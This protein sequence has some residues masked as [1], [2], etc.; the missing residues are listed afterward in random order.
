MMS[1]RDHA[2]DD[3]YIIVFHNMKMSSSRFVVGMYQNLLFSPFA[4]F[5]IRFTASPFNSPGKSRVPR[6][7]QS[8]GSEHSATNGRGFTNAAT[9][10][11][12]RSNKCIARIVIHGNYAAP[13]IQF[14]NNRL[15]PWVLRIADNCT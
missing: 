3:E 15:R 11:K 4:I 2:W 9:V 1:R 12:Y 8:Q 6:C 5:S 7:R 14:L 10:Q 13:E